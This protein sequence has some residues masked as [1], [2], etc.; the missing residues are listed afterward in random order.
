MKDGVI[1]RIGIVSFAALVAIAGC[2]ATTPM[3]E[4][5]LPTLLGVWRGAELV[6]VDGME[7]EVSYI[8]TFTKSRYV[9]ERREPIPRGFRFQVRSGTWSSTDEIVTKTRLRGGRERKEVVVQKQYS[10]GDEE[11]NVLVMHPWEAD[12]ERDYSIEYTREPAITLELI[13]GT[14]QYRYR[15]TDDPNVDGEVVEG[16]E[17]LTIGDER[18]SLRREHQRD[19]IDT[20]DFIEVS[21]PCE[22]D[23]E[24]LRVTFTVDE[25]QG[26]NWYW[27]I[28]GTTL[29]FAFAPSGSPGSIRVSFFWREQTF[30]ESTGMWEL[31]NSEFPY[32]EYDLPMDKV[33]D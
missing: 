32:G 18:C 24:E 1:A 14:W 27:E 9:H 19:I 21:G 25:T 13:S 29:T 10:W 7:V 16:A 5:P 31:G 22:V 20:L 11:R 17:K 15:L 23:L 26:H 4:P 28:V 3:E 8:L 2:K 30:D 33:T 12:T 6:T